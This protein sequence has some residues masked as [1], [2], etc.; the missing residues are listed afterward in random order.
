MNAWMRRLKGVNN[1]AITNVEVTI[2]SC[3]RNSWLV[4]ARKKA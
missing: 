3:A 4:R 1:A 2:V